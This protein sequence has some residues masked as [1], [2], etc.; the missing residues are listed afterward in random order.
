MFQKPYIEHSYFSGNGAMLVEIEVGELWEM[1]GFDLALTAP[2]SAEDL[3]VSRDAAAGSAWDVT[4]HTKD[5]DGIE[6]WTFFWDIGGD[7][8]YPMNKRDK[9]VFAWD[10]TFGVSWGLCGMYRRRS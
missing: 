4:L 5:L 7:K 2:G 1:A 8:G 6:D 9:V 3:T 10:N